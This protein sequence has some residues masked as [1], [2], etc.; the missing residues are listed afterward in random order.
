MHVDQRVYHKQ[1]IIIGAALKNYKAVLVEYKQS[2]KE[3]AGY[4]W[5]LGALKEL[6]TGNFWTWD[7][8]YGIGYDR[9]AYLGLDKCVDFEKEFLFEFGKC[10]WRN[11]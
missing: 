10:M 1:C 5:N 9:Y 4:K 8:K 6:P 2:A 11:H 3:L 7:K